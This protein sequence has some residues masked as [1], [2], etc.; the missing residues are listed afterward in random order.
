MNE[1]LEQAS[2]T[3]I[4]RGVF[5][6]HRTLTQRSD[7]SSCAVANTTT[8]SFDTSKFARAAIFSAARSPSTPMDVF[9]NWAFAA[10]GKLVRPA[11]RTNP[12]VWDRVNKSEPKITLRPADS[13]DR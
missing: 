13:A 10:M 11:T 5:I 9:Q 3:N 7:V 6:P 12:G 8:S 4:A 2:T 1:S